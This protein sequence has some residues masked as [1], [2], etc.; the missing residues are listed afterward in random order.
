MSRAAR[1]GHSGAIAGVVSVTLFTW[2]HQLT[3]S[4][5]WPMFVPMAVAGGLS[6]ATLG[7]SYGRLVADPKLSSWLRF[8]GV[9]VGVLFLLGIASVLAFEP[10]TTMATVVAANAPPDDMIRLALPLTLGFTLAAAAGITLAY[11]GT[12][13]DGVAV[14]M[15]SVVLVGALGL[16]VSALG[17]IEVPGGSFW[18][19]AEF[20]GL[21]VL[22]AA[23]FAVVF[24]VI[25]RYRRVAG[26]VR[27][28]PS[29]LG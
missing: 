13:R 7:W 27:K 29:R 15:T 22:L 2:I 25:E 24:A 19:V 23:V 10:Q 28:V 1:F 26:P 6:G 14:L 8:N 11:R 12:W 3:I 21:I 9:F 4:D 17:L 20:F 18:L 5:I 16:N